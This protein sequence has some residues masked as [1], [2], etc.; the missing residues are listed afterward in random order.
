MEHPQSM[1]GAWME[2]Q[3]SGNVLSNH[4]QNL[5]QTW[6]ER[7]KN[8]NKL[9]HIQNLLSIKGT[10]VEHEEHSYRSYLE[11]GKIG[12]RVNENITRAHIEHRQSTQSMPALPLPNPCPYHALFQFFSSHALATFVLDGVKSMCSSV[13]LYQFYV[14]FISF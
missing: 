3:E 11:H 8:S 2:H 7:P 6:M 10:V 9:K 13:L 1:N 4:I 12:N 5:F 14:C